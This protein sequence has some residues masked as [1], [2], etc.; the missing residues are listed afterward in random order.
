VAVSKQQIVDWKD[1]YQ[2]IF[3]TDI[4]DT[5]YTWRELTRA[6]FKKSLDYFE[7]DYERAEYLCKLCVLYPTDIDYSN[8]DA[9]I[10]ETLAKHILYESGFS[11]DDAKINHLKATYGQEMMRFEN[12]ISC[13]I[14]EVFQTITI[15]EIE[16]WSM[17]KTLWYFSRAE[18]IL[19]VL[20][21]IQLTEEKA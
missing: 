6:E 2:E 8:V 18:W 1:Q 9:G 4:M 14:A 17:E 10:P 19:K 16:N 5:E 11:D 12:Q 20:R 3:M 15:E 13:I 7:D 21:G